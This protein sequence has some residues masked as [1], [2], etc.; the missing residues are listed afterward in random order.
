[1]QT[2]K[3]LKKILVDFSL[4]GSKNFVGVFLKI[5]EAGVRILEEQ[6]LINIK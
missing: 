2:R 5:N 1:M 6:E 3:Q 4:I